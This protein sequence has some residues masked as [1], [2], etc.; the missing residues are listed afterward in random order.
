MKKTIRRTL[1]ATAAGA[2][3]AGAL[4]TAPLAA[5][6]QGDRSADR[7][8]TL[9]KYGMNASAVGAR[10]IVNGV[11]ALTARDAE[12]AL[13]CTRKIGN[14]SDARSFLST[15]EDLPLFDLSTST[16]RSFTYADGAR[17]GVRATNTLG[18]ILV[19]D[20]DDSTPIPAISI[21]GL[22]TVADAFHDRSGYHHEESI[23]R[24]RLE[25]T[26]LPAEV[27]EPLQQLLD[28]IDTGVL[29]PVLEVL[30]SV[31]APIQI[32]DLGTLALAGHT[33]GSKSR[34]HA[35]SEASALK[36]VVN[37][38][39]E[40][41][42][43]LLGH[44]QARIG[45]PAP[46]A[47][48]RSTSMPM[49]IDVADG[50]VRLGH[51][52]P[53]TITC[54]GTDGEVKRHHTDFRSVVLPEGL[55]ASISA[56]DYAAMGKQRRDGTARGF[57]VSRIG[58]FEIPALD[59]AITGIVSRVGARMLETDRGVTKVR[60]SD[61][62]AIAKI[63]HEGVEYQAPTPGQVLEVEGLGFLRTRVVSN[64]NRWGQKVTALQLTLTEVGPQPIVIDLGNAATHIFK[65]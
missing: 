49:S 34:H 24:M 36:I 38:T 64:G 60:K 55:L 59:L 28:A 50:A 4:A 5:A 23:S 33:G 63:V 14:E 2:L 30:E 7:G 31:D 12:A 6:E 61:R 48:F 8:A 51:I 26:G 27:N 39:G 16:S 15:P 22:T 58:A 41:Q 3:A 32:P 65:Y 47:V 11:E 53:R 54:E 57:E 52:Q 9:V 62:T 17:K 10:L 35:E 13:R 19:G 43:L 40:P 45:G 1:A 37:P 46:S 56:V 44:S 42:K 21:K 29:A 25:I 18:D 20:L